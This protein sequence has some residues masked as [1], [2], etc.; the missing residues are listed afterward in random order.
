[1]TNR[2]KKSF[3]PRFPHQISRGSKSGV[4]GGGAGQK[5]NWTRRSWDAVFPD[6][7][8]QNSLPQLCCGLCPTGSAAKLLL[9]TKSVSNHL[10]F[11]RES[12]SHQSSSTCACICACTSQFRVNFSRFSCE[13]GLIQ[14]SQLSPPPLPGCHNPEQVRRPNPGF[15]GT[16]RITRIRTLPQQEESLVLCCETFS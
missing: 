4:W 16:T 5:L 2:H 13:H 1:M 15:A 9:C 11:E 10:P 14:R 6:L 3:S 7:T 8:E 12:F